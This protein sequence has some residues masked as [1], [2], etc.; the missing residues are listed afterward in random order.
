M[1]ALQKRLT[2]YNHI[3]IDANAARYYELIKQEKLSVAWAWIVPGSKDFRLYSKPIPLKP[4][5]ASNCYNIL[6]NK[7]DDEKRFL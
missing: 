4:F 5:M 1:N 7:A 2:Q 6:I 3:T